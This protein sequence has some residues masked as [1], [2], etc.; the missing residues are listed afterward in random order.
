MPH[1]AWKLLD[2]L[3][4]FSPYFT[5]VL[6]QQPS[7]TEE[8]FDRGGYLSQPNLSQLTSRLKKFC[9]GIMEF[10]EFCL[11]LRRFK[12]QEILRLAARDLG[13]ISTFSQTTKGLS[14]LAQVCLEASLHFCFQ[15]KA[16]I[17]PKDHPPL[18]SEGLTVL[19]LGKLG[20]EELNFSSDI[21]LIFLYHLVSEVPL[22]PLEQRYYFQQVARRTILAMGALLGGD[23]VF[24]IDLNLRPGGKDSDLVLSYD[25][26]LEYYQ[27]EART[28]ERQALIKARPVAGNRL[29]GKKFIQEIEPIV[30]RK[31]IDYTVLS[32]IRSMKGQILRE[33]RSHSLQGENLKLGPG[34]IREIEFISQS[35][36]MVFGGRI[37]SLREKNTLRAL[38]KLK[39]ADILP[40]KEYRRLSKAYQFLRVLE[41]RLQMVNQRQTHSL[42]ADPQALAHIAGETP[43]K[44]KKP[45]SSS[46]ALISDLQR[47]REN[48]RS[49]FD[50]LLLSPSVPSQTRIQKLLAPD[51]ELE[52]GEVEWKAL[53]FQK[54]GLIHPIILSWRKQTASSPP[55]LRSYLEQIHP[56]LV[57]YALQTANPDQSLTFADSF[58]RRVGGRTGILAML[59]EKIPLTRE[60]MDLFAQSRM[61]GR[62]FSQ[63]PE[64]IDYLILQKTHGLLPLESKKKVAGKR[65]GPEEDLQDRLALLRRRKSE[66][67]LTTALE[68]LAGRITAPEASRRLSDLADFV[69]KTTLALAEEK[70]LQEVVH[71]VYPGLSRKLPPSPF[72]VLGMGK[73]G[74]QELGYLSDLDLIFVYSLKAPFLSESKTHSFRATDNRKRITYHEYLVRLAQRFISY[75][76]L[77]L[78]EGPGYTVDTRLRPS[79]SVG[80]LIVSLDSFYEYYR[81]QAGNWERQALLKA[82][83]IVG[84]ESLV[85]EVGERIET[86]L[87]QSPPP[88]EVRQEMIHYRSRM[89]KERSGEDGERINP[90]LGFGGLAD[91]EFITQYLQWTYLGAIPALRQTNTLRVLKALQDN[92]CLSEMD[93]L[94]LKEAYQFLSLLD[95]GLQ[96]LYDRKGDPRTYHPQELTRAAELNVL[97]L[98]RAEIPG[99]EV[100]AHYRKVCQNVRRLFNQIFD[101]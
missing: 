82:R 57:G 25:S 33:A 23:H 34:G 74:G 1:E 14:N 81:D 48:V 76:S 46:P 62:L 69:L 96:L 90:K 2:R 18:L 15:E 43:S 63:N 95:H 75:L 35:L 49:A 24:R 53:G 51:S 17:T 97:G 9:S 101:E 91:I 22:P 40:P 30:Y 56:L 84:P 7:L 12:Q 66:H 86:L 31:F 19:G 5:H 80:P 39:E 92:G 44:G 87:F 58:L 94:L 72:C 70:I 20:G 3:K 38:Q 11:T 10:Q 27:T 26:V 36:Q 59:I 88:F 71:P 64:M 21:D 16:A 89:E 85:D 77:P 41:H 8:L 60:I 28:W 73:L 47:T 99:W 32:E 29:L 78:G 42:P 6:I 68:E 83:I 52:T 79:G 98:G 13:G 45:F 61:M 37:P 93:F 50:N 4:A 54:P 67:F 65:N 100:T 55:R